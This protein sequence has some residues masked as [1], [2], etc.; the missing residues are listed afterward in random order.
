M[1][2]PPVRRHG[3]GAAKRRAVLALFLAGFGPREVARQLQLSTEDVH[4]AIRKG[5]RGR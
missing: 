5:L 2:K 3:L 4:R 1:K